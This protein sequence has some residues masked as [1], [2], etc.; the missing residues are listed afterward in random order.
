MARD[1]W[2]NRRQAIKVDKLNKTLTLPTFSVPSGEVKTCLKLSTDYT[3]QGHFKQNLGVG[4]ADITDAITIE[5]WIKLEKLPSIVNDDDGYAYIFERSD[6]NLLASLSINQS[7]ALEFILRKGGILTSCLTGGGAVPV[8][9]WAFISASWD[10]A[11][12]RIF[13]NAKLKGSLDTLAAPLNGWT[14]GTRLHYIGVGTF[15]NSSENFNHF[16]GLID[17]VRIWQEGRTQDQIRASMFSPRNTTGD[18]DTLLRYYYKLQEGESDA[19]FDSIGG[20]FALISPTEPYYSWKTDDG[21]PL[22]YGASKIVRRFTIE[23]D[24]RCS[25]LRF[26]PPEEINHCLCVGWTDSDGNWQRRRLYSAIDTDDYGIE[27]IWP[28]PE[29]YNGEPLSETFYLEVWNVDGRPTADLDE[30]LII[31]VS[32]TS[33]PSTPR[34]HTNLEYVTPEGTSILYDTYPI[35]DL[36]LIPD[37]QKMFGQ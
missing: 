9:Q 35:T 11:T 30:E 26:T 34:D 12:M 6:N 25:L 36:Q 20:G 29:M 8:N 27:T 5:A 32:I 13:V 16:S 1:F 23:G 18:S 21:F 3:V 19:T 24:R 15:N 14:A 10:G 37:T 2:L 22:K 28:Y 4:A 31:P 17:E 7:G 33:N